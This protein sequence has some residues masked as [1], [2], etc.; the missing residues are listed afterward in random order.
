M[1]MS[2]EY[3]IEADRARVWA[4]LNDPVVLAACIPGCESLEKTG[5]DEF[6]GRAVIALGPVKARFSGKV[7]L[8]DLDPPRAYR[9]TGEGTGGAAGFGK[10]GAS[11]ILEE[12]DAATTVLRYVAQ[13]QVGGK[14]AQIGSRLIQSSAK[15]LA[16]D[17]FARFAARVAGD[18]AA[19]D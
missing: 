17:F 14:L 8:S 10:G 18:A 6:S 9:L 12:E 3:R 15:K 1:D 4:A 7:T 11:V 5:E 19:A 13:A 16:D 2:G